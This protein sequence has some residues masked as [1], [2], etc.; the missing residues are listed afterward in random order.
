LIILRE[1][2][3]LYII[4]LSH[5]IDVELLIIKSSSVKKKKSKI[6]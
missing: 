1:K 3:M 4:I 5:F 2:K 6:N